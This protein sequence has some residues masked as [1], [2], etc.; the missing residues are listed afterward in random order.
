MKFILMFLLVIITSCNNNCITKEEY[1]KR[2]KSHVEEVKRD[3]ISQRWNDDIEK[4]S[5]I[6]DSDELKN[7][8]I[9]IYREYTKAKF[10]VAVNKDQVGIIIYYDEKQFSHKF[11]FFTAY[12]KLGKIVKED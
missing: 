2:I 4:L 3:S 6:K 12:F 10:G 1:E 8:M 5:G 11:D 7:S 9:R